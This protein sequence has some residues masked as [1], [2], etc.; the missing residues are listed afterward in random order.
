MVSHISSQSYKTELVDDNNNTLPFQIILTEQGRR[1]EHNERED[2]TTISKLVV[3]PYN[4]QNVMYEVTEFKNL[5]VSILFNEDMIQEE[6]P[7]VMFSWGKVNHIEQEESYIEFELTEEQPIFE[8]YK[9]TED[10]DTTYPWSVGQYHFIVTYN[11]NKFY[12]G[13]RVGPKSVDEEGLEMIHQLLESR[14]EGLVID[15]LRYKEAW[16]GND[17]IK[18]TS[19]WHLLE[20]Y[21]SN[22]RQLLNNLTL[23]ENNSTQTIHKRYQVQETPKR[24]DAKSFRWEQSLKGNIYRNTKYLNACANYSDEAEENATIK[25]F[26]GEIANEL[27]KAQ[28]VVEKV[29]LE[30]EE[31]KIA[32]EKVIQ[33]ANAHLKKGMNNRVTTKEFKIKYR[34]KVYHSSKRKEVT[35]S[36]IDNYEDLYQKI[37]ISINTLDKK[38][39]NHF[40]GQIKKQALK[41]IAI[42]DYPA[43]KVVYKLFRE[44]QYL[45]N[46]QGNSKLMLPVYKSTD[47]LYEYFIFFSLIDLFV[48]NDFSSDEDN[49]THQINNSFYSEGLK[50]GTTITLIRDNHKI[51]IVYNDELEMNE[52]EAE[53]NKT[54]FFT[55]KK[56]RKPDIRLDYYQLAS[57]E[58]ASDWEYQS[59]IV[60]EIKYSPLAN[61][62]SKYT[63]TK[64]MA[65]MESYLDIRKVNMIGDSRNEKDPFNLHPIEFVLCLYAGESK[66]K[67]PNNY[68]NTSCG[69]FIRFYPAASDEI[70]GLDVVANEIFD[71]WLSLENN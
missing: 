31:Q 16:S 61:I 35:Q 40:W 41:R 3:S 56:N 27:G 5:T 34:N 58:S 38:M 20:W 53:K 45:I 48:Q 42:G 46:E 30:L 67:N 10:D 12:G 62:Y 64:A 49:I 52:L 6:N 71:K 51:Q 9:R 57:D 32:I 33:S 66:I 23:I 8:L 22:E 17:A 55:K 70:F 7:N 54:Y 69:R 37:N 43:Y 63:E 24:L 68:I 18:D 36:R 39:N 15:Y 44:S 59:S 29:T 11:E 47:L 1:N 13:F 2:D 4:I 50:E 65:Q 25:F 14:I 28:S 26:V 19:V 21:K 60:V